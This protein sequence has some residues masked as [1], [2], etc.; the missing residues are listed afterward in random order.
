MK[1]EIISSLSSRYF[2][3][4][5]FFSASLSLNEAF[6]FKQNK[7]IYVLLWLFLF[8]CFLMCCFTIVSKTYCTLNYYL[9]YLLLPVCH[10]CFCSLV[11]N[12]FIQKFEWI[13]KEIAVFMVSL[14]DSLSLFTFFSFF[15]RK[16]CASPKPNILEY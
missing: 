14:L 3:L 5:P 10:L 1:L 13:L 8:V 11:S 6:P 15:Y 4:H 16:C 2:H 7:I 9:F 12:V